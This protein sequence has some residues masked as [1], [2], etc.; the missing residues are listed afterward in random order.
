VTR[1]GPSR[2]AAAGRW[3]LGFFCLFGI[4]ALWAVTTPKYAAPDEPAQA[5]KAAA[6]A[7]GE[8]VG[9]DD[10]TPTVPY[11]AFNIPAT[12]AQGTNPVCLA[13]EPTQSAGCLAPWQSR[14]GLQE[15]DTYVGG[16]PPLYYFLVG[17]PSLVT[18]SSKVLIWMR[19]VSAALSA[20]FLTAAFV[21]AS[22]VAHARATVIGVAAATTPLAVFLAGV[23]NPSGLEIS[24]ALCLWT[25]GLALLVRDDDRHTRSLVVWTA[26]SAATLVQIRG[27]SPL[28]L[29][30]ITLTLLA[31]A[32]VRP[33]IQ[34][35]RRKDMRIAFVAVGLCAA[36]A[37]AWILGAGSLHLAAVGR[38]VT[39]DTLQ[40]LRAALS[41][42][43]SVHKMIGVFG[44][45]DTFMPAW[46]Y[47]VWEA[48]CIALGIGALV[49]RQRRLTWVLVALMIV[50]VAVPTL[51]AF[52]QAHK[53]GIVGQARDFLP[54]AAGL[55]VLAAYTLMRGLAPTRRLG[56]TVA[57]AAVA[58]AAVQV[59]GFVQALH[60][61][62][63]GVDA[64]IFSS[65]AS[66]NPPVPWLAAVAAFVVIQGVLVWWWQQLQAAPTDRTSAAVPV[67][68][69]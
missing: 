9:R 45:L 48:V 31:V 60:R 55:P 19:L 69:V 20:V 18:H 3:L 68:S 63:T 35:L 8:L 50:T 6:T 47:I 16:Y 64:P 12:L 58:I 44:W 40:T 28:L 2:V 21:S 37:L 43:T 38:P 61:Y 30:I 59:A 51:L 49:R 62:R 53:L 10:S 42:G 52:S 41:V 32:G 4:A 66:W 39:G 11:M 13:F 54:V 24:S 7:R 17:L 67:P 1:L 33:L 57:A 27:L 29:A 22:R 34:L 23:I 25:S 36:F 15:A 14:T 26:V 56:L 65:N 46:C 5:I